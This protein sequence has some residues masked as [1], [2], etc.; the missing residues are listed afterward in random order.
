MDF[1]PRANEKIRQLLECGVEIPNPGT[2]D[3]GNEVNINNISKKG[4]RIYPGCRI[5]GSKMVISDGCQLGYEAPV[6]I[7]DCQLGEKVELKGGFFSKSVF[8]N[9]SNMGMGAHVREGCILEE[10]AGGA[11]C[12]GLK[13]TILFPFVTLGSLINFCD[14]LMAGGTSRSNHS[15]V[16]S[17]YIHFN[18]TP[19]ADK[20]TPSL[21]GDVPRGV[22]LNQPPIFLGGQGGIIGPMRLGFGNVVAAGSILRHDYLQD[23]QLIF[24]NPPAVGVQIYM[25][26]AYPGFKRI[27]ENNIIYLANLVAL[28]TWYTHVRK[29]FLE[30]QPWGFLLYSGAMEQLSAAKKERLKR[31][32]AMAEKAFAV[33][34]KKQKK[35]SISARHE[36]HPKMTYI[37]ELFSGKDLKE[38]KN[39]EKSKDIF[40]NAFEKVAGK[41]RI[42]Y[43]ETIQNL[44]AGISSKGSIWLNQVVDT[45]CQKVKDKL[46]SINLFKK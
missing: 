11:H 4:V 28:E 38:L 33:I 35:T 17:S 32:K 18:F 24:E 5:Y 43:I 3:I 9:K 34:P 42:N 13:Q 8:L 26:A 30:T 2:T 44:P 29:P 1:K 37:E 15:E 10:E 41:D 27:V 25:P 14:C 40:L 16:G 7:E 12:V 36:L 6:T 39:T 46:P 20:T 23:N 21:L 45:L 19:D 22:M 31:L